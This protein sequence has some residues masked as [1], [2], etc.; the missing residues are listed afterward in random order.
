VRRF[1]VTTFAG[2]SLP[3]DDPRPAAVLSFDDGYHDFVEHVLPILD[4]Y[5]VRAN[6]NVIVSTVLDGTVPWTQ[7]LVDG[8]A[9]APASLLRE[10]RLPGFDRRPPGPDAREREMYGIALIRYLT[11]R[12]KRSRAPLIADLERV[13]SR[14]DHAPTRMM[15]LRDVRAAAAAGH[16]IGAHSYD[17]DPMDVE[18]FGDF[19][20]DLDRCERSFRERLAL[21]MDVYAFPFGRHRPEHVD[22]LL[23]RGVR[24]ILLVGDRLA[25]RSGPV[26][27]RLALGSRDPYMLRLEALGIRARGAPAHPGR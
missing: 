23:G 6:Q 20:A 7:R 3:D 15:D 14:G 12:T 9:G 24:A 25:S 18:T 21:P 26:Y 1:R 13:L 17:H 4:R 19:R 8:L 2:L 5:G 10:I 22:E 16:E 27:A 11:E